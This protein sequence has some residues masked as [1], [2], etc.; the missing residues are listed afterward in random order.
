VT[1]NINIKLVNLF[2]MLL[3][4]IT[5]CLDSDAARQSHAC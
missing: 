4:L 5:A 2:R 3:L 1:V